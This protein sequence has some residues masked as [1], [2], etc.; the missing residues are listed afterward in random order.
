M[1]CCRVGPVSV[2]RATMVDV[3]EASPPDA[4]VN[5]D[6]FLHRIIEEAVSSPINI[7]LLSVCIILLYK[8]Y[9]ASKEEPPGTI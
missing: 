5:E 8:I 9:R 4:E 2:A 3:H 7:V 6:N 1:S